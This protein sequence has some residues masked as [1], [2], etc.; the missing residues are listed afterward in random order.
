[1][2][3]R[4]YYRKIYKRNRGKRMLFR[5]LIFFGASLL[6]FVFLSLSVFFYYAKDLPRPEDFQERTP[7]Q[8]TRIYDRTGKVLLYE[9]YGDEKR[10]IIPSSQISE[11]LKQAVISTED[12]NFYKH[13][14][15]DFD[16]IFRAIKLDLKLRKLTYGGST[17][18]Q[19]LIRSTF[20]STR[21]TVKRKIREI[22]LTLELE[23]RYSK[24]Q[25][26][27]WYLN[28]IPFGP[29]IYGI[30]S[31]SKNYFNKSAKDLS[32]A[33]AATLAAMIKAPSYYSNS[34]YKNELLVRRNYVLDRMTQEHYL[35][36]EEAEKAKT[37]ELKLE[38]NL[39]SIK[40]PHFVLYIENYLFKKYGKDFLEQGG[41]K[42]YTS[43]D[44][45]LQQ[46]AEKAVK[47]GAERNKGYNAYNAALVAINPKTDQILVMVG[48]KDWYAK[49][50][51]GCDKKTG[52]CKFDPKV[53]VATYSIGRQPG[54]SFKPFV[55]ATAFQ[56]GYKDTDIVIDEK[57]DF[58][59]WGGKHYIPSNYDGRFR[60]PVTLRQALAQSLNIPSIKVLV[61]LA[62]IKKSIDN[63]RK[64]GITTLNKP[65]SFYGPSIV[66]G[67][68][69][70]KLLDMVS[71]YGVFATEGLRIAPVSI[72][73]I[74]NS[75][76]NIIEK[77]EITPKRVLE[78]RAARL[79]NSIL[80][81]NIARAPMFGSHSS[82]YFKDYEV[83]A[84]TGTT[85]NFR[86]AWIIGYTPSIVTG[87][88]VGN[89]NN[90]PMAK[91]PSVVLAAPIW[92]TFM[93]KALS[94]L[95]KENFTKPEEESKV[96]IEN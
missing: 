37:E 34:E 87:V 3:K 63:A 91:E 36:K 7:I 93:L 76:G 47:E 58:G 84:K 41:F 56:K 54:S 11:R 46:A 81:D 66:L 75:K 16:G 39:Q 17:I 1:M 35:T 44:W 74:E 82:L 67:G 52:K 30:E 12:A 23:R 26:L 40:A 51:E 80:S 57:T 10:E 62:G 31:A 13:H 89:N 29:N 72:L 6:F 68:G 92:R 22:I 24:K 61:N 33:E 71:A 90:A 19:Q 28:Q 45:E 96:K 5:L 25:I 78:K 85:D 64:F 53:N 27:G 59:I 65:D 42:I 77:A 70:V 83:A 20:L 48:S 43:L 79:I 50:P 4:I 14:G 18:S 49:E 15:I 21:K 55:Y 73:K 2:A 38:K 69:E 32:S 88:W 9:I 94:R 8:S 60:G 86:D 95:P